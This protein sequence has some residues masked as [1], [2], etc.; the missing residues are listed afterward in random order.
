VAA[1]FNHPAVAR[2]KFELQLGWVR[3]VYPGATH[4]RW[5][6]SLG[7]LANVVDYY[8]ALMADPELPTAR[9]LL[10][11]SD[12]EHGL[13]AAIL[14]DVAQT[15]FGH[16]LEVVDR[17]IFDHETLIPRLLND[18]RFAAETLR[19][20]IERAWRVDVDRVLNILG[21]GPNGV[22]TEVRYPIDGL[23][24]DMI[25]GPVDADKLDYLVRDSIY[26]GVPYGNGIDRTRFLK[27]L[28]IE[29]KALSSTVSILALAYRAKGAAAIESLLLARYQ[30]YGAV[31]WHHTFRCVQAMFVH[32]A[33][34]AF[35]NYKSA[36][37]NKKKRLRDEFYEAVICGG[38]FVTNS[39][40]HLSPS[41]PSIEVRSEPTLLFVWHHSDGQ[42]RELIERVASRSLY[43]RVYELRMGEM[44]PDTEY[45][46]VQQLL[47]PER[48]AEMCQGLQK[49][50]LDAVNKE[51]QK[52]GAAES[53][54][55]NAA[56][57]LLQELMGGMDQLIVIDFPIRGIPDEKNIPPEIGDA[58]RKYIS[59]RSGEPH[60][61][62]SVF[63]NVRKLQIENATLRVF[64]EARLHQLIIRY[65]DPE[66][67][68]ACVFSALPKLKSHN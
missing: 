17:E 29:A 42:G 9:L 15:A 59:G 40:K 43:K 23:A 39:D 35:Q 41:Q 33:A 36:T 13:V 25:S 46:S 37:G 63:R 8:N 58:A 20:T 66:H 57:Q 53:N 34:K 56:R 47:A 45:A 44:P 11:K 2:L 1:V 60:K 26:C 3:E 4:T 21:I 7:V 5:S 18:K 51:V 65:L 54:T 10:N 67:V 6:H 27:A 22:R 55:E 50:F 52:R 61:G 14:H 64:A 19:Q 31:Y 32:A 30:L 16:D 49:F 12:I 38:R 28:T 68:E 24:R 62:R 48:R